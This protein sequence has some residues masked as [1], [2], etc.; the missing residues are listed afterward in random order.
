LLPNYEKNEQGKIQTKGQPELKK[1]SAYLENLEN[2][3]FFEVKDTGDVARAEALRSRLYE[4]YQSNLTQQQEQKKAL[5]L[6]LNFQRVMLKSQ[7]AA[8]DAQLDIKAKYL[9]QSNLLDSQE[10]MLGGLMSE[11]Q[12]VRIQY[13]KNLTKASEAYASGAAKAESDFSMGLLQDIQGQGKDSLRAAIKQELFDRMS[14]E[15]KLGKTA[16]GIT[17]VELSGKL[18]AMS[19]K[20]KEELLTSLKEKN[21][22]IDNEV[23]EILGNRKLIYDNQINTLEKQKTLSDSQSDAQKTLNEKIAQQKDLMVDVNREMQN[24]IRGLDNAAQSRAIASEITAARFGA[25]PQTQGAIFAEQG[26]LAEERKKNINTEYAKSATSQLKSLADTLGLDEKQRKQI[27][28]SPDRLKGMSAKA[29]SSMEEDLGSLQFSAFAEEKGSDKHKSL[30]EQIEE[31]EQSIASAKSETAKKSDR[32]TKIL[33]GDLK[34]TKEKL[35]KE[36]KLL[37]IR[38]D[39]YTRRTGPDAFGEG[40]KDAGIEMEKRVAMMDYELA[41]NIPMKFA[42]GLAQAMQATLN[43]TENLGDALMGIA[44]NFLQAIQSALLQKAA[45]QIVGGVG[46]STGLFSKGGGVRNYSR[47]GGVPAMVTNGEYVMGGDAVSKY[48]GAF[49]HSLNAGGKIPGY[50]NGGAAPGSAIAENFGGGR[51]FAS[52]RAYQSKAMSSFFYT[53]SQNVGLKEDE[54][55]LM[56]VLQ[57]EERK[58]QEAAAKKA[59]KKQ[60]IQQ[61]IG[62]ALTAGLTYGMGKLGGGEGLFSPKPTGTGTVLKAPSSGW[63][64]ISRGTDLVSDMGGG[65]NPGA[66]DKVFNI[67]SRLGPW[68]PNYYGGS[69]R[70]YANGGHISG[71][72][73]IDQI[74]AMLSEGEYVIKASSARQLGKPMLDRINAGKYNDGGA[75]GS[76]QID[77]STSAGNTNNISISI[78]ME[79]GKVGAEEKTQ[80]ANP[81]TSQEG[82]SE[83]DQSLLAEKIKQQVVSVIVEEQRPGGLLSE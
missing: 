11:E 7:K 74:P 47:G 79:N 82:S 35:S 31:L 9:K 56:G 50:A 30:L 75:V 78:N 38:K 76:T 44:S 64:S 65:F 36:D 66:V 62:T 80:D 60:F 23:N 77:S 55:S 21:K 29:I 19:S 69:I 40:I 2:I 33:Q 83:K 67:D 25:R 48:G 39:E 61:L 53:Q 4:I 26:R 43:Q 18:A 81:A 1:A 12:K 22:G 14:A 27:I 32:I 54:Q 42:D 71:K 3:G 20:E 28:Q 37:E 68:K 58:R 49:M 6:Q 63:N 17:N 45:Y 46:A 15:E 13:N 73:G 8:A 24:Y 34:I 70:K 52:G 57:E 16:E 5:I 51:G 72:S 59:K 41:K 10:K